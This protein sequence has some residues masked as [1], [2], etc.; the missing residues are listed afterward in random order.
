MTGVYR[1]LQRIEKSRNVLRSKMLNQVYF[2]ERG[3]TLIPNAHGIVML[4]KCYE[5]LLQCSEM[6][7]IVTPESRR[8]AQECIYGKY[9]QM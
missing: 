2:G 7:G 4:S 3:A 1:T 8:R 5:M 9:S 6:F